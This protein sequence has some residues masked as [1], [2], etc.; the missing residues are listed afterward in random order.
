MSDDQDFSGKV[1]AFVDE[2]LNDGERRQ[3]LIAVINDP[4][5]AEEVR[6]YQKLREAVSAVST[7]M[8]C[9]PQKPELA[10][11]IARLEGR[12]A[13]ARAVQWVRETALRPPSL[14]RFAV[15]AASLVIVLSVLQ[16][17]STQRA[18][19][20]SGPVLIA[21]IDTSRAL[22]T[23]ADGETGDGVVIHQSFV[24]DDGRFCRLAFIEDREG[25][26]GVACSGPSDRRWVVIGQE[27]ALDD[28]GF[29]TAGE[30]PGSEERIDAVLHAMRPATTA[31]VSAV[32]AEYEALTD[33]DG[34]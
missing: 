22:S 9:I 16:L 4:Q 5:L 34:K 27:A 10:Q 8:D 28:G 31:E 3:F 25:P 6:R 24:A 32:L 33:Q 14:P 19:D 29:E 18:V 1:S 20:G 2:E 23:L 13:W 21:G 11:T 12:S 15:V 17:I 26:A 7:T 30:A